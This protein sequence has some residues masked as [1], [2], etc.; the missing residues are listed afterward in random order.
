MRVP[1]QDAV[2]PTRQHLPAGWPEEGGA[3]AEYET[4]A[5]GPLPAPAPMGK[6]GAWHSRRGCGC[7]EGMGQGG[8]L[9]VGVIRPAASVGGHGRPGGGMGQG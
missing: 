2:G 9:E 1:G 8:G 5:Q 6:E 3:A 4:K 7:G